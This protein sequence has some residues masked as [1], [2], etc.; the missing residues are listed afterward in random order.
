MRLRSFVEKTRTDYLR[1]VEQ[2]AVFLGR[3]P[4]NASNEDLRSYH[5]H[6]S[7]NSSAPTKIN[8]TMSALRFLF[9]TVLGRDDAVK[10]LPY[11]FDL[12]HALAV[13]LYAIGSYS[14]LKVPQLALVVSLKVNLRQLFD[15][16]IFHVANGLIQFFQKIIRHFRRKQSLA[17]I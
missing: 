4:D 14:L 16:D 6:M 17:F 15:F 10:A 5:L 3:S 2:L 11:L 9:V 8:A 13:P 7:K 1:C 12:Q